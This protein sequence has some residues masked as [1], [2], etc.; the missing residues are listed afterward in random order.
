M[1]TLQCLALE[2]DAVKATRHCAWVTAAPVD[3]AGLR[4]RI[5]DASVSLIEKEGLVALSLRE[6]ARRA[7]V[8]HQAPYHHFPD[9]E[10]ILA[11]IAEEG[12]T[13][14]KARIE[15]SQRAA[16]TPGE[17]MAACGEQYVRFACEHPAHFR[18]MFRPEL[19]DV[20]RFASLECQADGAFAQLVRL[21][22]GVIADGLADPAERDAV[23]S[24]AWSLSHGL[25]SLLLDGP[26]AK[27]VP[28]SAEREHHV[29]SVMRFVR[30]LVDAKIADAKGATS[31]RAP[32]TRVT[33]KRVTPKRA[34]TGEK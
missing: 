25:A 17:R 31:K 26:L 32:R 8:S 4:Q 23:V 15:R 28:S 1:S 30:A 22:D 16:R 19:V 10:A 9:R 6:V 3:S 24:F 21:V 11:A 7:G 12:F 2:L 5:L 29:A 13:E 34:K 33:P 18:V 14:L 27:K 20:G